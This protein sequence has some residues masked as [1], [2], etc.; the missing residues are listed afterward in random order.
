MIEVG[1]ERMKKASLI[2]I[3]ILLISSFCIS[4]SILPRNASAATLYV[5]GGG[6]GN[7]TTIQDAIN[8]AN[9]GDTVYVFA[10]TYNEQISIGIPLSLQG[11]SRD[12]TTINGGVSSYVVNVTADWVNITGFTVRGN[13]S[14]P[15]N[16]GIELYYVQ[17]CLITDNIITYAEYGVHLFHSNNNE[18]SHNSFDNS[19]YGTYLTSSTG[20]TITINFFRDLWYG[21]FLYESDGNTLS[22]TAA[23]DL[24]Y[25]IRLELSNQNDISFTQI[26]IGY[27]GIYLYYSNNSTISFSFLTDT[28]A[29]IWLENSVN[30]TLLA[31]TMTRT[32]IYVEGDLLEHWNTHTIGTSNF[33]NGKEV[34]YKKDI[35]GGTVGP[36]AGQVILANCQNM[37]VE[38]QRVNN[39]TVG[40]ELGFS[41]NNIINNNDAFSNR[42]GGIH[43]SH[44]QDNMVSGNVISSN[45]YSGIS[46]LYSDLNTII[47]N[48]VLSNLWRGIDLLYSENNTV[49]NNTIDMNDDYGIYVYRSHNSTIINNT[50]SAHDQHGIR[51]SASDY[52][53]I[54]GNF[55]SVNRRG[56]SISSSDNNLIIG[57]N[58]S[59]NTDYGV[60]MDMSNDNKIYH[61]VFWYNS[62]QARESWSNDQWDNGYPSGGNYWSNYF[63][64][65]EKSGVNQ[66]QPGFDGIGDTPYF[67]PTADRRDRYPYMSPSITPTAPSPPSEPLNLFA[68]S[69]DKQVT[70]TWDE[71]T[72]DGGTPII[73]YKIYRG[74]SPGAE[75][76]LVE[77]G[78]VLSHTDTGLTNGQ[79]YYYQVSAVTV[80]GEG[81]RSQE[82]SAIPMGLPGVPI[83]VLAIAG[84]ERVTLQWS[85]PLDNGGS[86]ITNYLIYRQNGSGPLAFLLEVG[87]VHTYTDLGLMNGETYNYS[88]A[89][90]SVNGE[91]PQSSLVSATPAST[92][93]NSPPSCSITTPTSGESVSGSL[94]I[95]GTAT[96]LDGTVHKVEIR[97]D[98]GAWIQASGTSL[99]S[100]DWN[101]QTVPDAEHAIHARSF[102][103]LDYS[104]EVEVVVVVSNP[105]SPG[106]DQDGSEL[107]TVGI[108]AV[109]ILILTVLL[110][111]AWKGK[112]KPEEEVLEPS[113]EEVEQG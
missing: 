8:T 43:L 48:T 61:N 98:E 18:V 81:P 105:A 109:I 29:G 30:I 88:I 58:L 40:I 78:V 53:I 94:S 33:V 103:G 56:M 28:L 42:R 69:G 80:G 95:T 35:S 21:I 31:N 50:V 108:L 47:E 79:T 11:E 55:L 84:N 73:N 22:S 64:I 85:A 112:R 41:S 93:G 34:R 45:I 113:E 20:N 71:P 12:T 6:P 54:M 27:Y 44:S 83:D 96:D 76:F 37:L 17:N 97:I 74:T 66:D 24:G 68:T 62:K 9:P 52:N 60:Y 91:G 63:G 1:E 100:Y 111:L 26:P 75:T 67:I 2:A 38:N 5:G 106:G 101:T 77:I 89:A 14:T 3:S 25:A 15:Y 57:N 82:V 23:V 65:D 86:P 32:G 16:V 102:D 59:M 92:P 36:G 99:W 19:S 87:D 10:G 7:Y 49:E 13:W 104:D 39:G 51:L 110:I 4:V 46:L 70:L 107:A 90:K 72:F